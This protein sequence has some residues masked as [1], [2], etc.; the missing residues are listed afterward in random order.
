MPKNILKS[1]IT[2]FGTLFQVISQ[3]T[4]MCF[5]LIMHRAHIVKEYM[6]ETD[7]H[8]MEWPSQS[9]DINIIEC[10]YIVTKI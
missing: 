6:E 7:L 8:S 3:M 4:I 2:L 10:I 5:N 1:L 9:P